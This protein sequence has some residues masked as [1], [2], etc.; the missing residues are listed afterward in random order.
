MTD[1][2]PGPVTYHRTTRDVVVVEGDDAATYLQGQ[3]SQDV[4]ALAV[5]ASAP[6]FVLSPQGKVAGWGRAH[7][8]AP[9]R[10]E[11]DVDP[12][13][14][15]AWQARLTRFLLRTKAEVTVRPSVPTLVVRG[16]VLEAGLAAVGPEVLGVDLVGWDGPG[17]PEA[18][19]AHAVE[20]DAEVAE[21]ARIRAGVPAWGAELDEDTIPATV[22]QWAIDESVSFTKGCYTGQELVARIDSRGGNVPRHLAGLVVDGPAPA[23]GSPVE[24]DGEVV[25]TVTSA[26]ADPATGGSVALAFLP[27][28]IELVPGGVPV[29]VGAR[30]D[31]AALVPALVLPTPF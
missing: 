19:P 26:A 4:A 27:R 13:A 29:A 8:T 30:P 5:G 14:G 25:A 3:L 23:P 15:E 22:G 2:A 9:D 20:V 7:R 1:L 11:I 6:A 10:F 31:G 21:A 18:L 28:S 24:V 16:A 12:G 17:L